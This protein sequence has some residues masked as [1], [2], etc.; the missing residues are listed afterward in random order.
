M[1]YT[2]SVLCQS[3]RPRPRLMQGVGVMLPQ[4]GVIRIQDGAEGERPRN[5]STLG[6]YTSLLSNLSEFI[7]PLLCVG[8]FQTRSET[9]VGLLTVLDFSSKRV[10]LFQLV[11]NPSLPPWLLPTRGPSL[12]EVALLLCIMTLWAVGSFPEI[13]ISAG[14]R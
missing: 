13:L 11:A 3:A 4:R 12:P 1:I 10:K 5:M 14:E 9:R 2:A 6:V 7:F 8:F